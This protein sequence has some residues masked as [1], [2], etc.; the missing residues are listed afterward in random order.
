MAGAQACALVV[1]FPCLASSDITALVD[2]SVGTAARAGSTFPGA[3]VPSGMVQFSPV[4]AGTSSPGGYR[5]DDN[6]IS[7]FGL[8]RL[9]G[10]GCAN[11]GDLP[12]LSL[13]Q[14][15]AQ[16]SAEGRVPAATGTRE[17]HR[18]EPAPT[19]ALRHHGRHVSVSGALWTAAVV[20]Q[21]ALTA[22]LTAASL[23]IRS[24]VNSVL[25]AYIVFVAV[26]TAI[27][28]ALS[29]FRLVTR[30]GLEVAAA[31]AL[32]AALLLWN[33]RGRPPFPLPSAAALRA[34]LLDP[35]VLVLLLAVVASSLY[36]LVLVLG[37]P[38]NNWDSLTYHLT[39]A[40]DWAQYGGVHWIAN[41]PTD[42]INEFQ[43]LAEQQV[44]LLF[45]T[46]GRAALFAFP[47]WL[48]G[49]AA[50][51]AVF[52]AAARL[53]FAPRTA[54]FAALL[55]GTFPLVALESSTAQN[56]LV[57]A[58]L[59]IAAAALV[60]GG[61][62]VEL[63]LAG[64]ALGLALGVKL[65]TAYAVPIPIALAL[66]RGR[67]DGLRVAAAAVASFVLLGMWGFELNLV[68]TGYLLGHGGG[69]TEQ[70]ASPSLTGS[71]TTAFR[72]L[73]DLLDLSGLGLRLTDLLAALA[74]VFAAAVFTLARTRGAAVVPAGLAALAAALP[75]LVPR[76]VPLVAHG[77]KIVGEAV[78]LPVTD[79]AT[80]G[81]PFF[82]GI[83]SG[84]SEDLSSFGAIGGPALVLI[85]L[86]VLAR[87]H[88]VDRARLIVAAALPLFIVLLALTSKYNLWLSRFLLVPV[89]LAAP[90]LAVLAR[91]RLPAFAIAFVAVLQLALV[92]VHNQQ[93]P[94]M[95]THPAPW[96][97][98]QQQAL[99]ATFRPGYAAAVTRLGRL[100]SSTCVGAVLWGDD[101]GFLL[102]G[103]RLQHHVEFLPS[104]G[105]VEAAR[106]RGLD[107][108]V[109]GNVAA[110][111]SAFEMAGWTLRS[112]GDSSDVQWVLGTTRG[113]RAPP[114]R[115]R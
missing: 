32:G 94:L 42:R 100:P 114:N 40:A 73:H 107:S 27:T 70:Q 86:V 26:V 37:T 99:Q 84:S 45:V 13:A 16:L 57:A 105:A 81:A 103:S 60:L 68:H 69:R 33:R 96:N 48:A 36:A 8:T 39:R 92:H 50:I 76:L 52:S 17:G 56:D 25:A 83:D 90:L 5:Y 28:T 87:R 102:F 41:A 67:K 31:I 59:P 66:L 63:S 29:P 14:P 23:R 97:A 30:W 109:I 24:S 22:V 61:S 6:T 46:L 110:T 78:R 113:D 3:V 19:V 2:P 51:T 75:L 35:V 111:R 34:A 12:V 1:A 85:S 77:M 54:A 79:P 93:K 104:R 80:T 95:G 53:G 108:V 115:C 4:S 10:A 62:R 15:F 91:W 112:L 64:V 38:P 11:M 89:A 74:L 55:F 49:L 101:P 88:R 18:F 98:T 82:W 21:L 20:L 43:P 44:L 58:A 65:T 47:Q 9:S 72:V 7:G 106:S 71:P